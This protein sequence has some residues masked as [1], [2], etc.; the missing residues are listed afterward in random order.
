M[1]AIEIKNISK[2]FGKLQAVSELTLDVPEGALC[3]L[4]GP[5]GAGKTTLFSLLAGFLRPSAGAM[6]VRGEPITI[7]IFG[8]VV[9]KIH[10]PQKE[11][12]NRPKHPLLRSC[13]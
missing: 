13:L 3:G 4:I 1:N 9:L 2:T 5:N 7:T 12:H 10:T 6:F 11:E 8:V